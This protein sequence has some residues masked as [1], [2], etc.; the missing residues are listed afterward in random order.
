MTPDPPIRLHRVLHAGTLPCRV[1]GT[2]TEFTAEVGTGA[3]KQV[4]ALCMPVHNRLEI[5]RRLAAGGRGD[6]PQ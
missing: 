4:Y 3:A 6:P 1:C 5:A 2:E